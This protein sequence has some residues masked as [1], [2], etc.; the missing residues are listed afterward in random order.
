MDCHILTR[1]IAAED[2]RELLDK[3][4]QLLKTEDSDLLRA[5]IMQLSKAWGLKVRLPDR[6]KVA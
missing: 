6:V 4:K 1:D 5:H 3:L 2:S